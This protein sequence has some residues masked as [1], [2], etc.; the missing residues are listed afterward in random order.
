MEL[1]PPPPPYEDVVDEK[2]ESS[3]KVS[4]AELARDHAEIEKLFKKVAEQLTAMPKIA[5]DHELVKDWD[6]LRKVCFIRAACADR[7]SQANVAVEASEALPRLAAQCK[8]V[9][10]L[11]RG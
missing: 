7:S 2:R 10:K 6:N 5:E 1:H 4:F 9:R 11:S 3:L 8:R